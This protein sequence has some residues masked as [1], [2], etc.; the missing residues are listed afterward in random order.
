MICLF[1]RVYLFSDVMLEVYEEKCAK[2]TKKPL[3]YV[4]TNIS[5]NNYSRETSW[6][7]TELGGLEVSN[8]MRFD[9]LR[10]LVHEKIYI[11]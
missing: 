10:Y 1:L 9:F 11:L 8:D 2:Y 7:S 4:F 6:I 5:A 3:F